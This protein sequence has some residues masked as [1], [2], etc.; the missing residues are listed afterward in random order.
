MQ[1]RYMEHVEA[2]REGM[3]IIC[4][5][6]HKGVLAYALGF[7]CSEV[8]I[9]EH[10]ERFRAE[11]EGLLVPDHLAVTR[12]SDLDDVSDG[13]DVTAIPDISSH[14][15]WVVDRP[16]GFGQAGAAVA[17][18]GDALRQ[19]LAQVR[20]MWVTLKSDIKAMRGR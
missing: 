12:L 11:G 19:L 9:N 18:S 7:I 13:L 2:Q 3:Q 15:I 6:D 20:P 17:I 1:N 8:H 4:V 5:P 14:E 10:D 16:R